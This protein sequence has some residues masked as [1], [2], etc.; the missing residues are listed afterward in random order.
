MKKTWLFLKFVGGLLLSAYSIL[1]IIYI[2]ISMVVLMGTM[3]GK[4]VNS[5]SELE[6]SIEWFLI[7]PMIF[8]ILVLTMIPG[9][10]LISGY[11]F[12]VKFQEWRERR[13]NV[14]LK[15]YR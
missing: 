14:Y 4:I 11:K 9:L 3:S 10:L 12:A 6:K 8:V 7:H 15:D 2:V 13:N 5:G 1:V